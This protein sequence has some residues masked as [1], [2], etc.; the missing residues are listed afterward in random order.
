MLV[1]KKWKTLDTLSSAASSGTRRDLRLNYR[2]SLKRLFIGPHQRL[3]RHEAD[4]QC[5]DC[6]RQTGKVKGEYNF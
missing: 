1:A 2:P 6:G 5:L 3:V 4:L